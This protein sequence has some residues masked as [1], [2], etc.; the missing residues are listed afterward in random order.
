M[1]AHIYCASAVFLLQHIS[2][3]GKHHR[4]RICA[5]HELCRQKS[6][7]FIKKRKANSRVIKINRLHQLM[8]GHV[9]VT[10]G[11]SCEARRSYSRKCRQRLS[12]ETCK[13]EIEPDHVRTFSPDRPEQTPYIC[14]F[15]ELPAPHHPKAVELGLNRRV[16]VRQNGQ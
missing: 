14:Q 16:L 9:S 7:N 8:Q 15:V 6:A 4:N 11:Q 3:G 12:T 1:P 13:T 2:V 10:T 5:Q